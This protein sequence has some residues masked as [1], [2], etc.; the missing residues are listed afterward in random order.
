MAV[1]EEVR[2]DFAPLEGLAMGVFLWGSHA[3]GRGTER[4]DV[5]VCVVGGPGTRP[6]EVLELVWTKARLGGTDYDV[7]VFEELPLYLQAEVLE[8]GKL[9]LA[10]DPPSL[11]EYL[12]PWARRWAHEAHRN[13]PDE[14][15][16][17]RILAARRRERP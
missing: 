2:R 7:K 4:S 10:R 6:Y 8:Q 1:L 15:D 14:A 17:D 12:R 11:Y 5:D 3:E 16:V 9:A 13:R